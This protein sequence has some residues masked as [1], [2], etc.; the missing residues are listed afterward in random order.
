MKIFHIC[1][2]YS[3][4][5]LYNNLLTS[6]S[7]KGVGQ[8]VYVPVRSEEEIGKY[9]NQNLT[10]IDYKYSHILNK[11]DRLLYFKKIRKVENNI[12]QNYVMANYSMIHAHFL[13][14]DG[15]VAYKLHKKFKIPYVVAVRN[16]DLNIFFK[17]FIHLRKFALE[18]L[19]NADQIV[20][21]SPKYKE[22]LLENYVPTE[23][24]E[25]LKSKMVVIPNGVNDFWLDGQINEKKIETIIRFLYI[26]DF[27][28]NKN[29]P[30][31]IKGLKKI[32]GENLNVQFDIV[33]SGGEDEERVKSLIEENKS[34]INYHGRIH[35]QEKL[36]SIY[37]SSHIFVMPSK[38]ETFGVV[39]IEALSQGLPVIYT[40]GQGIDGFYPEGEI[41]YAVKYNYLEDF[42]LKIKLILENYS[43]MSVISVKKAKKFS[44][45]KISDRYI[46]IYHQICKKKND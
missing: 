13:F 4:Q 11:T 19:S 17:Y 16:T 25:S 22:F 40:E 26:G 23:L 12:L 10:N 38:T 5:A 41:G 29:I 24:R 43:E 39:Y 32:K 8:T 33:G 37:N 28:K 35:D 7:E 9:C 46:E 44:W 31:T 1:S 14:S 27:T 15:G 45:D 30:F 36:K 42:I 20:F 3:K 34:W 6:I 18:I 21:L 2:D